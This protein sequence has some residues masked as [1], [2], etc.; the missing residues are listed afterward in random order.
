MQYSMMSS[1]TFLLFMIRTHPL[2]MKEYPLQYASTDRNKKSHYK[3][4][5][6]AGPAAGENP[7]ESFS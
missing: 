7:V 1:E 3:H 2:Q 6:L 5:Y 4:L